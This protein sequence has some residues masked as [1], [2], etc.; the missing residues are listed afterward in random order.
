MQMGYSSWN[1][2]DPN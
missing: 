2:S 1:Y